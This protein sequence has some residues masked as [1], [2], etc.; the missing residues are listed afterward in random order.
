MTLN[1]RVLIYFSVFVFGL[2]N[3]SANA[4]NRKK[5]F[6][7]HERLSVLGSLGL[8]SYYGD[9]CDSW[10]CFQYRP[11]FGVGALYRLKYL[12]NL[13]VK[14]E[15][16]YFRLYSKDV[17]P[18]RNLTFRSGN[19]ELFSAIQYDLF[20]YTKFFRDRE[21]INPYGFAG[22]GLLY[23]DPRAELNGEWHSLRPHQT[24]G[25]K[26]SPIT[27]IIPFGVGV[28]LKFKRELDFMAEMGYRITFTDYLDDVSSRSFKP[29]NTFDDPVSAALSNRSP[30]PNFNRQRGNPESR[31]GYF[32]FSIK[33]R[34]TFVSN[35]NTFRGKHAPTLR[36]LH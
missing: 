12:D 9:L 16:N 4:Q 2:N 11:N 29:R 28:K 3:H 32:I 14:T 23:F 25:Q 6:L 19:V 15:L 8:S 10:S 24:E 1:I 31:D 33:A 21:L 26:Y 5:E 34:Y 35:I 20:P 13:Y 18:V 36:R 17:Y 27:P 30:N 22:I 7:L